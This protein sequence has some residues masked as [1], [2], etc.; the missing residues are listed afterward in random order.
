VT[1]DVC[2]KPL[3]DTR[4]WQPGLGGGGAHFDCLDTADEEEGDDDD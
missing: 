1:C 2:G 3:D 4:P